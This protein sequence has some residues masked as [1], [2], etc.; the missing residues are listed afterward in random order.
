ME[1]CS[2]CVLNS[3]CALSAGF[4]GVMSDS[5]LLSTLYTISV[6]FPLLS[7][8][9]LAHDAV[10]R[11]ISLLSS[12]SVSGKFRAN[13]IIYKQVNSIMYKP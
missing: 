12:L 6:S 10:E 7:T 2:V 9:L 13:N 3:A 5:S 11:N 8:R 4:S 1:C